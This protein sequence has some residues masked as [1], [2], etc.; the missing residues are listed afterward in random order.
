MAVLHL[1]GKWPNEPFPPRLIFC[2][3]L[4]VID[5]A[6]HHTSNADT[7]LSENFPTTAQPNTEMLQY[8]V[9][10]LGMAGFCNGGENRPSLIFMPGGRLRL[11]F[12]VV[13]STVAHVVHCRF[14]LYLTESTYIDSSSASTNNRSNASQRNTAHTFDVFINCHKGVCK[15]VSATSIEVCS[16][17]KQEKHKPSKNSKRILYSY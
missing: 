1:D 10:Q 11:N 3:A 12:D 5:A 16:L 8:D 7:T 17:H 14:L 4:Q 15:H 9:I 13:D 6:L 2:I